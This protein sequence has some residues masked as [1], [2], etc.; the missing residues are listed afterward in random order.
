MAEHE[1]PDLHDVEE[2]IHAALSGL[3]DNGRIRLKW[4]EEENWQA[5]QMTMR[6]VCPR[7]QVS[8]AS[9]A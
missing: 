3:E 7:D 2:K 6:Q 5:L 8:S 9:S 1:V 4:V